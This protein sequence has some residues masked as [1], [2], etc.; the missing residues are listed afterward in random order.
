MNS[1]AYFMLT[2]VQ[3]GDR[4]NHECTLHLRAILTLNQEI[5]SI[6]SDVNMPV[7]QST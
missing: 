5:S 6:M 4:L 1:T 3:I 2:I 7:Y